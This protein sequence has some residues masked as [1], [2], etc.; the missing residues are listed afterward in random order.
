MSKEG[1]G[2]DTSHCSLFHGVKDGVMV[3]AEAEGHSW[4]LL[5]LRH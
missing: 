1:M 3:S 5:F 4:L 2:S